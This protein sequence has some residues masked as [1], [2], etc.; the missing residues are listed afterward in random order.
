MPRQ[1]IKPPPTTGDA[2][3]E[4]RGAAT[5]VRYEI[6][7][8]PLTLRPGAILRG[9]VLTTPDLAR[10]AFRTGDARLILAGRVF[11]ISVVAH[12]DGAD[13]AYFEMRV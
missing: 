1:R 8:D 10:A 7:G 5:S 3:L 4:L 6:D 9:A 13:T 2:D 11:R 12:T